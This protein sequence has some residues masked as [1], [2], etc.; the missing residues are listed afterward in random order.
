[1][2]HLRSLSPAIKPCPE[3]PVTN[4]SQIPSKL[5]KSGRRW[6]RWWGGEGDVRWGG[7]LRDEQN[8]AQTHH[9]LFKHSCMEKLHRP[10]AGFMTLC[11]E[12][13]QTWFLEDKAFHSLLYFHYTNYSGMFMLFLFE[14]YRKLREKAQYSILFLSFPLPLPIPYEMIGKGSVSGV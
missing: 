4:K 11:R 9:F 6:S 1:M 3:V 2:R 12:K 8:P 7:R 5:L 10:Q 13:Q 14:I